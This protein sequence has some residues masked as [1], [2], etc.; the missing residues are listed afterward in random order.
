MI[1]AFSPAKLSSPVTVRLERGERLVRHA[2]HL[3]H[4]AE[5]VRVLAQH[6]P[7]AALARR[8]AVEQRAHPLRDGGLAG[9]PPARV[10]PLVE[11][12]AVGAGRLEGERRDRQPGLQESGDVDG[13]ERRVAGGDGVGGDERETVSRPERDLADQRERDLGRAP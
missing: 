11:H 13:Q 6:E 9:P 2:V 5:R 1:S 4:H 8:G 10:Q 3:R 7:G 12:D